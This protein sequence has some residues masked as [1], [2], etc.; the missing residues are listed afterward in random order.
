MNGKMETN[1]KNYV[2]ENWQAKWYTVMNLAKW[3]GN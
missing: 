1:G 3:E 2:I